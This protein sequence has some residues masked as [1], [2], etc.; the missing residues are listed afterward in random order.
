MDN[1]PDGIVYFSFGSVIKLSQLPKDQFE[2]IIR[3]LGKIKQK[4]L[5]KWDSDDKID[6]P[7]NIIIRKWFPQSDILGHPNCVLFITHG[8]IHSTEEAIYYGVPMLAIS[9]FG[10]QLHNSLVMQNRGAAIR[11]KY[12]EF[13]EDA[14]EM[15]LYKT[16]HDKS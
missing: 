9:V 12:S 11:I 13:S 7:S 4:V 10:D 16:L 1:A 5:F 3:Q 2:M 6:F 8:G 15:A 14:F